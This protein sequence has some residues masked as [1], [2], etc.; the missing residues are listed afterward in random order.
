M[1]NWNKTILQTEFHQKVKHL[2]CLLRPFYDICFDCD[3][4]VA[5]NNENTRDIA[6]RQAA[7]NSRRKRVSERSRKSQKLSERKRSSE[8]C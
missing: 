6:L 7:D 5:L 1:N 2:L 8:R 4:K 3:T